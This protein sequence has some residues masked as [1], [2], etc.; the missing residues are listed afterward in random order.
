MDAGDEQIYRVSFNGPSERV[1]VVGI[2]KRKQSVRVDV[3]FLDGTKFGR[4]ENISGSRLHGPWSSVKA[5]DELRANWQ[6]LNGNGEGL[7]DIEQSA[8]LMVL[9]ALIPEDVAI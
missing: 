4:R 2:E 9:I 7:D 8:V 1:R 5:F 3:E 6:R